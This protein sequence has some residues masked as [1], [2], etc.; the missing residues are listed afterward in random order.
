MFADMESWQESLPSC[1]TVTFTEPDTR[2]KPQRMVETYIDELN[3]TQKLLEIMWNFKVRTRVTESESLQE[4]L[5]RMR[6]EIDEMRQEYSRLTDT[7]FVDN[8]PN[9]AIVI[10]KVLNLNTKI[11]YALGS[12]KTLHSMVTHSDNPREKP[13][14]VKPFGRRRLR[15]VINQIDYDVGVKSDV[16]SN[17]QIALCP[18]DNQW[19]PARLFNNIHEITHQM[20]NPYFYVIYRGKKVNIDVK[21]S[22][23]IYS[24]VTCPPMSCPPLTCIPAICPPMRV[25]MKMSESTPPA[26]VVTTEECGCRSDGLYCDTHLY[27]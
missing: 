21:A 5:D 15:A 1:G 11:V 2:P 17:Q 22:P 13:V 24:P 19:Q 4:R 26:K 6:T 16:S 9:H 18:V 3:D 12:Y 10:T 14:F 23:V 20:G 7:T 8:T 25:Q 27:E